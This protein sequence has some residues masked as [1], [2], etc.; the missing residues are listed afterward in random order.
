MLSVRET[1]RT[2]IY[3]LIGKKFHKIQTPDKYSSSGA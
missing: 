3:Y 1:S 2:V